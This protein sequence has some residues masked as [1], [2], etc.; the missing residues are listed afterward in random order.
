MVILQ[1]NSVSTP[2]QATT[3]IRGKKPLSHYTSIDKLRARESDWVPA[4]DFRRKRHY[5]N[6][7]HAM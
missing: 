2:G 5:L 7:G 1:I 3:A 6:K 4:T